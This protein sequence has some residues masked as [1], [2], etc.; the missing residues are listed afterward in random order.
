MDKFHSIRN[1][2]YRCIPPL[3]HSI[4]LPLARLHSALRLMCC[5][6]AVDT[7]NT[8]DNNER[9]ENIDANLIKAALQ[10]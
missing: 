6:V 3:P 4:S 9:C 10:Q 8:T 2:L 7:M 5:V 1:L